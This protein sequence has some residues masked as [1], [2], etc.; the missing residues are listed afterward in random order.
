MLIFFK[1][2]IFYKKYLGVKIY[3][4]NIEQMNIENTPK[5]A[6]KFNCKMCNFI[7]GKQSDWDRHILTQKHHN[8][9][10]LNILEQKKGVKDKKRQYNC[11]KCNKE[12]KARNSLWY[13]EQKCNENNNSDN[14]YI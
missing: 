10:N 7:C 12:Y 4:N 9:I 6:E 11:K 3:S 14:N 13:H 2:I 1:I 5:N 8:R